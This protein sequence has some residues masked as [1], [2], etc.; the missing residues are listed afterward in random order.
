MAGTVNEL[1]FRTLLY[2]Y[3]FF[4]WLFKD[5]NTQDGFERGLALQH[6][7]RQAKWLPT[8]MLR[9]LWWGLFF[10]ALG[11]LSELLLEAPNLARWLYAASAGCLAFSVATA[12][13]WVGLTQKQENL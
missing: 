5:V 4:D 11:G 13:A 8:Y 3:F 1:P 9:W 2:R 7:K 10:Y 12:T 6:N